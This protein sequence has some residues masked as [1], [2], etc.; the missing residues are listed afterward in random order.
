MVLGGIFIIVVIGILWRRYMRK[1]RVEET[2]KFVGEKERRRMTDTRQL[3]DRWIDA[4]DDGKY[5]PQVEGYMA[6]RRDDLDSRDSCSVYSNSVYSESEDMK[7]DWRE[8][9]TYSLDQKWRPNERD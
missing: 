4:L 7:M 3:R 9:G 2:V 6:D 5:F 1:R 8:S